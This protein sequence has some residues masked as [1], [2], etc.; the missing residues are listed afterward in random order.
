MP[1]YRAELLRQRY[2]LAKPKIHDLSQV[3]YLPFDRDD[4]SYARDRSGYNN[5]GVIYGARRVDGVIGNALSFDGVDDRIVVANSGSLNPTSA[6]T[7][8]FWVILKPGDGKYKA[9]IAKFGYDPSL[10]LYT[11]WD[12]YVDPWNAMGFYFRYPQNVSIGDRSPL[13]EVWVHYALVN[14]GSHSWLYR[15][16]VLINERDMV[17]PSPTAHSLTI[18][19]RG[20]A[21]FG[22]HVIDEVRMYNRALSEAE[23]RRIMFM[24][25]V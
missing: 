25:G 17:L 11:G 15:N 2:V 10:G 8:M 9:V 13:F 24:S 20:T 5:H 23:I 14:N 6:A 22:D 7:W 1:L 4:G 19:S 12:F 3:L 21:L 16:G 18:G